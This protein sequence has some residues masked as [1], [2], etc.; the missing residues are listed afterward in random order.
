MKAHPR[1]TEGLV[2]IQK[3]LKSSA[4]TV[5]DRQLLIG[6]KYISWP[7]VGVI[8][9]ESLLDLRIWMK[10]FSKEITLTLKHT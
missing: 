9:M 4:L 5:D 8:E 2:D 3:R 10:I 7:K 6:K 1:E